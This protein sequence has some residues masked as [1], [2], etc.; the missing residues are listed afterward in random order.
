MKCIFSVIEATICGPGNYLDMDIGQCRSCP[1][2]SYMTENQHAHTQCN[3]CLPGKHANNEGSEECT[4]CAPGLYSN[5]GAS[6]CEVCPLGHFCPGGT[7]KLACPVGTM[8]PP[9]GLDWC[10]R[11]PQGSYSKGAAVVCDV[12]SAGHYCHGGGHR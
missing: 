11:C 5:Q 1:V 3:P 12:C 2:G 6:V 10:D 7:D 9:M 4:D 8:A